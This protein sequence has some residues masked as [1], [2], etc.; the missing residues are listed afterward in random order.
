MSVSTTDKKLAEVI[1]EAYRRG[2]TVQSDYSRSNAEYVAM[3]ASIGLI[4]TRL[5]GNVYSREWRPT[6]KGL[7]WLENTF[8][9]VIESDE[10]LD[11]GHD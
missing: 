10:D 3:A 5:Y 1:L 11:E 4:S 6:V 7:V 9:V 8:G 2:F